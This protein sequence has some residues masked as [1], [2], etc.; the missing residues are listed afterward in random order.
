MTRMIIGMCL[1]GNREVTEGQDLNE[2]KESKMPVF[3]V[4]YG[5]MAIC[6]CVTVVQTMR[7]QW[8][9]AVGCFL[10]TIIV[11]LLM[12]LFNQMSIKI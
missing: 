10:F 8:M 7:R 4:L 3:I 11:V 9:T 2:S 5:L 6:F 1:G 12:A